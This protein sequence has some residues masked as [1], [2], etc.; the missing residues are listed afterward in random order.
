[1]RYKDRLFLFP[2]WVKYIGL[3]LMIFGAVGIYYFIYLGNKP[4]WIQLRVFTLW[5]KF[6]DTTVCSFIVNN[7]GDELNHLI[8][9][10]GAL[11]TIFSS[12]KNKKEYH[13][14]NKIKALSSVFI[15]FLFLFLLLYFFFHGLAI[16]IVTLALVYLLPPVYFLVYSIFNQLSSR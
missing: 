14:F 10:S 9:F 8:Y 11:L 15:G 4:E 5:S 7:Q 12:E 6:I 2:Y 1:V 13:Y 16:I 3:A